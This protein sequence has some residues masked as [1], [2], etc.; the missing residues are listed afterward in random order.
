M[1]VLAKNVQFLH[2]THMLSNLHTMDSVPMKYGCMF[3]I[4]HLARRAEVGIVLYS[5][6]VLSPVLQLPLLGVDGIVDGVVD[7]FVDG[8]VDGVVDGVVDEVVGGVL[9][10]IRCFDGVQFFWHLRVQRLESQRDQTKPH[11][12][13]GL[14][15]ADHADAPPA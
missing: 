12:P 3:T 10:A 1:V 11:L 13:A 5:L 7:G 14:S 2:S 4:R 8:A 15:A 9:D 6:L